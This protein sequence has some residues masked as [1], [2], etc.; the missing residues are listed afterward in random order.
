MKTLLVTEGDLG[1]CSQAVPVALAGAGGRRA[2]DQAAC[3]RSRGRIR[4]LSIEQY[5][6]GDAH[7][8]WDNETKAQANEGETPPQ[9][10]Q[11]EGNG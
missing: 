2:V 10:G 5:Q 1:L 11:L 7:E 6:A 8:N 4:W 9:K 3:F